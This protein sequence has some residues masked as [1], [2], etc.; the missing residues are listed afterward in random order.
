M[1]SGIST[2]ATAVASPAPRISVVICT[3]DRPADLAK[4]I[5]SLRASGP[6]AAQAEVVVIEES[7][8]PTAVAG[9]RHIHHRRQGGGFGQTRNRGV[10]EAGG[11]LIVFY[12]DDCEAA[13]GWL[14]RLVAPLL[15]DP[16]I[17]GAA[18]AVMVKDCHA[19]GYAENILGFPGGG[20]R[21]VHEAKGQVKPIR[22]LSTCNCVYRREALDRAGGFPEDPLFQTPGGEDSVLAERV[23]QLGPCVYVPDA[24]IYHRPRG[25]LRSVFRWFMGRGRSEIAALHVTTDRGACLRYLLRGSWTLRLAA[26]GTLCWLYPLAIVGLP[27]MALL[28]GGTMLWRF[29]FA[30][31][32]ASHRRGWLV[33]PLV[34]LAMDLGTEAGRIQAL[35]RLWVGSGAADAKAV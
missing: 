19:I 32:Y 13:S 27:L 29:R 17:L 4:A 15:R 10:A 2:N 3:K 34:K 23:T 14:D 8:V 20:L 26:L 9:V 1:K 6:L 24:V 31:R 22:A 33:V 12:D 28:Y 16:E 7:A 11:E 21:Y 5:A 35:A 25:S 30:R 18:G